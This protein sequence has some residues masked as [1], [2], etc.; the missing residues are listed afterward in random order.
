MKFPFQYKAPTAVVNG[1]RQFPDV[2][3]TVVGVIF[4]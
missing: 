2:A 1:T 4:A 3:C